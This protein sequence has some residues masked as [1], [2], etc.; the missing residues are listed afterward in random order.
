MTGRTH[1]EVAA[2]LGAYALDAVDPDE[3]AAVDAH[4]AECPRCRE[5][6]RGHMDVAGI[7]GDTGSPAPPGVWDRIAAEIGDGDGVVLP[8]LD[9][10]AVRS[11]RAEREPDREV[12]RPRRASG[13]RLLGAAA[14]VLAVVGL[15]SMGAVIANQQA[16]LD[17][18]DAAMDDPVLTDPDAE[19][20]QLVDAEGVVYA[21]AVVGDD[22]RAVLVSSSLGALPEDRSY[23]LWAVGADGPV[24]LGM[25]GAAPTVVPFRI[26]GE[27]P[28][29]L[30]IT[31][32]PAAGSVAPTSD[33]MVTGEVS[34]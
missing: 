14:A 32:E 1:D 18:M 21:S 26:T 34:L 8:P 2:L 9:L 30:A 3:R 12:G 33:P 15:G 11:E 7:L 20:V 28:M 17:E 24:S 19:V 23:Q 22:G 27:V 13:F 5:E 29:T 25:L 16:R 6:L 10:A 4:V 31:D